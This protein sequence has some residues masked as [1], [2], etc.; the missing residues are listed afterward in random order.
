MNDFLA[1]DGDEYMTR[2]VI[3]IASR[4]FR[5]YSNEGDM[6]T[7]ECESM[8]EFMGVLEFVRDFQETGLLDEDTVV[9]SEP[10]VV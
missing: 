10:S 4:S 6:K 1:N 9:Y 5:V 7:I 3:D 2:M 8:E